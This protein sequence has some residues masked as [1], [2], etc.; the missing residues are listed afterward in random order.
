MER[1]RR[2]H[3]EDKGKAWS[4]EMQ[5]RNLKDCGSHRGQ[6]SKENLSLAPSGGALGALG[7]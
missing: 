3:C 2:A 7:F 6:K 4:N 1:I 5:G